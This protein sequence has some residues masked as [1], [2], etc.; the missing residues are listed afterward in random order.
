M[1]MDFLQR[2]LW[3]FPVYAFLGWCME[4]AFETIRAGKFIN[5]G[6]LN[7]SICPIHGIGAICVVAILSP[8]REN[9]LLLFF[10]AML[11]G[12]VVELAVGVLLKACF[13]TT[14]W[15]YSDERLNLGGYICLKFSLIW[16]AV[17]LVLL[18][19]IHPPIASLIR[20][21]PPRL[22]TVLL[23]LFYIYLIVDLVLSLLTVLKLNRDLQE[24]TRLSALIRKGSDKL[25][26]DIGTP[27]LRAAARLHKVTADTREKL[28]AKRAVM[29]RLNALYNHQ[30][31]ARARL[32]RAFPNMKSLRSG[33][34]L[35]E[36]R[37]RLKARVRK[38]RGK[39][40]RK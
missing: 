3:M 25:T 36:M 29:D 16:G 14:W 28:Y 13:Q 18:R 7:G 15:D 20:I 19:V 6:F 33:D 35:R 1:W 11:I 12:S 8:V 31:A 5:R 17:G 23:I 22:L 2:S 21:T 4:T 32:L 37:T 30:A 9:L 38:P 26:K 24:I 27:A 40:Q 10:G 34:A 39:E